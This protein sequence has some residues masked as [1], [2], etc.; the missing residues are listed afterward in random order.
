MEY[1]DKWF[2]R[3]FIYAGCSNEK[4]GVPVERQW[5]AIALIFQWLVW[6]VLKKDSF[7]MIAT[8]WGE[9]NL[10]LLEPPQIQ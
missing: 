10:F 8:G 7:N 3:R 9:C 6:D 5:L 2:M 4:D 1:H